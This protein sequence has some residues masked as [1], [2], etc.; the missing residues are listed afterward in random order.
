MLASDYPVRG[1][2]RAEPERA[3]VPLKWSVFT[4]IGL[5]FCMSVVGVIRP[6]IYARESANWAAQA[7]GQDWVD[8]VFA[9]PSL[10][11][12][13]VLANRGSRAGRL[14][15]AG[16][17]LYCVYEL[18]IY[19]FAVHFNALFLVYVAAFG[20]SVGSLVVAL[21]DLFEEDVRG[22]FSARV[23]TKG[24]AVFL[25]LIG[26]GFALLWLGEIVPALTAGT[27]PASV[28]EA[29][30]PTNPVHVL[31]LSLILPAHLVAA[32]MLF[33]R[34]RAGYVAA[35]V[36]LAF[37]VLM[38]LSI[39]GMLVVMNLRGASQGFGVA[40]AMLGV[41]AASALF[42]VRML[43]TLNDVRVGEWH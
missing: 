30:V 20:V 42:L 25:A 4:L 19:A 6:Q 18:A 29:S 5:L 27:L 26:A 9:V 3:A 24:P 37:G 35:P 17:L 38:A 33:R 7:V 36:L 31:D 41:S 40:L 1:K 21:R 11:A 12:V 28:A 39:G 8:L 14:L 43:R 22:W 32:V 13:A 2:V 16:G 15:L 23:P 34:R 10:V